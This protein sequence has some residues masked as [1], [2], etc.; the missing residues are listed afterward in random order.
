MVGHSVDIV[1]V[2]DEWNGKRSLKVKY[3]NPIGGPVKK[4]EP[5]EAESFA[6]RLRSQ[7]G[8][9]AAPKEKRATKKKPVESIGEDD[10]DDG[11]PVPF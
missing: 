4:L 11:D 2:D 3:I 5:G 7:L 10:S 6:D 9:V 1:I 8:V